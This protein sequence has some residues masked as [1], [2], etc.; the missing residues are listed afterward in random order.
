MFAVVDKYSECTLRYKS[1][2]FGSGVIDL[3]VYPTHAQAL[4]KLLDWMN[5]NDSVEI[6]TQRDELA[7]YT[8]NKDYFSELG[9]NSFEDYC[10]EFFAKGGGWY[11]HNCS[12]LGKLADT[13]FNLGDNR[14][15]ITEVDVTETTEDDEKYYTITGNGVH[16]K[17]DE[18]DFKDIC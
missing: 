17:C 4:A 14:Y 7:H 1:A 15:Y 2:K 9:I 13:D 18:S 6:R 10:K 8:E 11:G 12:F 3:F 5:N 16:Y